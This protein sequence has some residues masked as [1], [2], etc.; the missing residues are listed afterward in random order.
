M[1]I[2]RCTVNQACLL[3]IF[4]PNHCNTYRCRLVK[5][6]LKDARLRCEMQIWGEGFVTS[7][8]S[9]SLLSKRQLGLR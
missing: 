4:G 1:V 6:R 7:F 5:L 3:R 8:V 2:L 9:G